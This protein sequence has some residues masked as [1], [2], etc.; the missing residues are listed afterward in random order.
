MEDLYRG[1][2]WFSEIF[3]LLKSSCL[4]NSSPR[5]C[6]KK[7][8]FL[9]FRIVVDPVSQINHGQGCQRSNPRSS[10][11][12]SNVQALFKPKGNFSKRLHTLEGIWDITVGQFRKS[13]PKYPN[14]WEWAH[15]C[16]AKYSA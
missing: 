1:I 5:K 6:K 14:S 15:K 4:A 9:R 8:Y 12:V 16:N 2:M 3:I 7:N 13:G 11:Q 10:T